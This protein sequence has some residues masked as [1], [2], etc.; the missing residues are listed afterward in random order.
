[1]VDDLFGKWIRAFETKL[2]FGSRGL[3]MRY[4]L[5]DHGRFQNGRNKI[6]EQCLLI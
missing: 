6:C 5:G 1:M 4:Y 2:A 3:A